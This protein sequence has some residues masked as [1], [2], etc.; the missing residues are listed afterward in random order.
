[1]E[2]RDTGAY[3]DV[4]GVPAEMTRAAEQTLLRLST[5]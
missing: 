2:M 4:L 5:S 1:M 3:L